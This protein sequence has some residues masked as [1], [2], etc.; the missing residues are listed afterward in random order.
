MKVCGLHHRG[1]V[2]DDL[3]PRLSR[4]GAGSVLRGL[5]YSIF[6]CIYVT[7]TV[8][9]IYIRRDQRHVSPRGHFIWTTSHARLFTWLMHFPIYGVKRSLCRHL[10]SSPSSMGHYNNEARERR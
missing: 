9:V 7:V 3:S 6:G 2:G 5:S 10:L 8:F 1:M 4:I